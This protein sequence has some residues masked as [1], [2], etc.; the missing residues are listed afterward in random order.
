MA[1]ECERKEVYWWLRESKRG[2]RRKSVL[3][4][5]PDTPSRESIIFNTQFGK[6]EIG[7]LIEAIPGNFTAP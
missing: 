5:H 3:L 1:R 4:T 7:K 2:W 6:K